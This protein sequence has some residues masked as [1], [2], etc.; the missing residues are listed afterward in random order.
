MKIRPNLTKT[1]ISFVIVAV[2]LLV[3]LYSFTGKWKWPLEYTD[4]V[5]FFS[6]AV[7]T[8]VYLYITIRYGFYELTKD[9]LNQRRFRTTYIHFYKDILFI[10]EEWSRK[11]NMLMF[12]RHD[13]RK[14]YLMLDKKQVLLDELLL[15]CKDNMTK[16]EFVSRYPEIKI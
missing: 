12:V 1:I 13:K 10:D 9:S 4:I 15:R 11:N 8:G 3:V 16:E 5:L 14:V 6:W 7:L 2:L